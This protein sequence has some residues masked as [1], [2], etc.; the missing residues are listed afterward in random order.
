MVGEFYGSDR[1]TSGHAQRPPFNFPQPLFRNFC[2]AFFFFPEGATAHQV[3]RCGGC[4]FTLWVGVHM[5][6]VS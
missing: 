5:R 4:A 2:F 3:F 1:A 6:C